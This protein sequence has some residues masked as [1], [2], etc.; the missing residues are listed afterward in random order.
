MH[1]MPS[2]K[3]VD[4]MTH[5]MRPVIAEINGYEQNNQIV[6]SWGNLPNSKISKQHMVSS[7]TQ[8]FEKHARHLLGYAAA[9]IG[10]GIIESIQPLFTESLYQKFHTYQQKING[11]WKY[12]R[13][14][15]HNKLI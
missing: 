15:A 3:Q 5:P 9:D 11:D 14:Y 10:D 8:Y 1:H 12:N 6:P 4:F 7:H 2:P 13:V